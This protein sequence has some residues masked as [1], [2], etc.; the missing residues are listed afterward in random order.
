MKIRLLVAAVAAAFLAQMVFAMATAAR[1]QSQTADEGVYIGAAATYLH[2]RDLRYNPEHPP[3]AKLLIAAGLAGADIRYD[4]KGHRLSQWALGADVLYQHGNGAQRVLWRARLPMIALTVLFG[5]VVFAFAYRLA[6]PGGA[7][8]ALALYAFSPDVIT[9]GSLAGVDL[10]AAGFLLTCAWLLWLARKQ[11]W[12]CLPAGLALGAA[13]AS[14]MTALAAV[15]IMLGLAVLSVR[16]ARP[17]RWPVVAAAVATGIGVLAV[18]TVWLSYLAV[19]PR[20]GFVPAPHSPVVHGL[21]AAV[22]DWLP[23]PEPFRA[24][25]RFQLSLEDKQWNS[26]LLGDSYRG[27]RW[28]YLPVAL[29]IKTPLGAL[30]LWAAGTAAMLAVRRLRPAGLYVL[31]PAGL[32]LAVAMNGSRDWGVRYALAVPLFLAVAAGALAVVLRAQRVRAAAVLL[33]VAAMAASSLRA[34]PA[35]L[36]YSNEAFGGPD[37]TYR[38]IGDSNV[39][40]GQDLYRLSVR[41]HERY[42]GQPVSLLHRSSYAAGY[43]G[44]AATDPLKVPPRP[45]GLLAVSVLFLCDPKPQVTDLVAGATPIDRVGHTVIIYRLPTNRSAG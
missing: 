35:Y 33:L 12:W 20:L 31:L 21:A 9:Y 34:Y 25:M 38:W 24:G 10:P 26:F 1:Q 2:E 15:P 3:L 7:L 41:L 6:G 45:G 16:H 30:A 44:I 29:A 14:K 19:D 5:L 4:T 39:D 8:I 40:W 11:V 42:P 18:A 32:L 23:F 22:V 37:R 43:Y 28:Y 17:R 13:V 36:P 27:H